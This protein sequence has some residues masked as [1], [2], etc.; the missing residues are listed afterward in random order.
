MSWAILCPGHQL[1][2]LLMTKY[3]E[4]HA[5]VQP[6]PFTLQRHWHEACALVC[7]RRVHPRQAGQLTRLRLRLSCREKKNKM[8]ELRVMQH[9]CNSCSRRIVCKTG[10]VRDGKIL[11]GALPRLT[12]LQQAW[13]VCCCGNQRKTRESKNR[14]RRSYKATR[15]AKY[16]GIEILSRI[17]N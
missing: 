4:R 6:S 2:G 12:S 17:N 16:Q 9:S 13:K 3:K 8:V 1:G 15:E 11:I 7:C 10:L 5:V 14:S